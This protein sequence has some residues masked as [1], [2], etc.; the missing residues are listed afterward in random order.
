M[1]PVWEKKYVPIFTPVFKFLHSHFWKIYCSICISG[2]FILARFEK[3]A[4]ETMALAFD[5]TLA[6]SRWPLTSQETLLVTPRAVSL[7][8]LTT[9]DIQSQLQNITHQNWPGWLRDIK[10]LHLG[11]FSTLFWGHVDGLPLTNHC[12]CITCIVMIGQSKYKNK[13]PL[14][15]V[16]LL[17]V[18]VYEYGEEEWFISVFFLF[19]RSGVHEVEHLG[20]GT[21]YAVMLSGELSLFFLFSLSF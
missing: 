7:N 6:C 18:C 14:R 20:S 2:I 11:P 1:V 9:R 21:S 15:F 12:R 19:S 13:Q 8:A 4:S 3:Y 10:W 16:L 5:L 17:C